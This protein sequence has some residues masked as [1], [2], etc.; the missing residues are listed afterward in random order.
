MT[1]DPSPDPHLT[2]DG[3]FTLY[4]VRYGQHYHSRHGAQ[5]QSERV[6]LEGTRT[7]LHPSPHVLEVG[8]GVGLNFL[9]TLRNAVSRGV[10][11]NY[12]AFEFDP[13]PLDVLARLS[14]NHPLFDHPVWQGILSRWGSSFTFSLEHTTVSVQVQDVTQAVFPENLFSAVYLDGFSPKSNPEVWTSGFCHSVA[15]ALVSGGWL[16]TYSSSGTVRRALVEAGLEVHKCTGLAGKREYVTAQKP[17]E[18]VL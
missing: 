14:S 17:V 7:H 4:S 1:R 12:L 2:P 16:S 8:F 18:A 15:S 5:T 11:L 10:S 9:T 6:Y 3:S 13:V